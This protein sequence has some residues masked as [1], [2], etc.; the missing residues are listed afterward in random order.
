MSEYIRLIRPFTA[1]DSYMVRK[2]YNFEQTPRQNFASFP[3][4]CDISVN[5]ILL[6]KQ[7]EQDMLQEISLLKAK[8]TKQR[9]IGKKLTEEEVLNSLETR[10][11]QVEQT[12]TSKRTDISNMLYSDTAAQ[13][14]ELQC[15]SKV[16]ECEIRRLMEYRKDL[17]RKC[18]EIRQELDVQEKNYSYK[19]LETVLKQSKKLSREISATRRSNTII[20][21]KLKRMKGNSTGD[22]LEKELEEENK[23]HDGLIEEYST[24]NEEYEELK[25][26]LAQILIKE[27]V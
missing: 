25:K 19:K 11:A 10:I 7:E 24:L 3:K 17:E 20:Q 12:I 21:R 14:S 1:R 8:V 4:D 27:N 6:L 2:R 22:T 26:Q 23:V 13:M 9:K 16:L 15:E 5:E 18:R